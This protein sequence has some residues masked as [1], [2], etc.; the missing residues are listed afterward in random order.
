MTEHGSKATTRVASMNE[1][2]MNEAAMYAAKQ[3]TSRFALVAALLTS[4]LV[5]VT[6]AFALRAIPLSG[7]NCPGDCVEY[8]YLDTASQFPRDYLWMPLAMVLM[9][10][11]AALMTSIHVNAPAEKKAFSQFG[12]SLAL[13]AAAVLL[14][15]YYIQFTVIPVSLMNNE[16]EGLAAII[17]YNP[18]GVFSG[19]GGVGL[20]GHESVVPVYGAGICQ[21][22]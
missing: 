1:A 13:I 12:H 7:A 5:V 17:Q 3:A 18:H 10:T 21:S 8:P 22:G 16:T 9:L 2:S 11:Y 19:T 14:A 4:A 20:P 6:F 15:D